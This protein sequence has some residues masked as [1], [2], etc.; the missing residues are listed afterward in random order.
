[1]SP[2]E[3]S[4]VPAGAPGDL[5]RKPGAIRAWLRLLASELRLIL[6][7]RRNQVGLAILAVVPVIVAVAIAANGG[8]GDLLGL[9]SANGVLVPLVA[10]MAES[11]FFL[12][13]AMAMVSG[14]AIA[15]EAGT[16]TLRYLLTVPVRR[17]RLLAVKYA[18]LV[19]G[20]FVA[21]A[22]IA[23]VGVIAGA[24]VVGTGPMVTFSGT[25]ITFAESLWR[26]AL[27]AAYLGV[28]MAAFASIG[29]FISTLTDQSVA[30]TI[31]L[32]ITTILSWIF[33]AIEQ[34]AWLHPFLPTHWLSSFTG[35]LYQPFDLAGVWSGLGY[36]G[37]VAVI[38]RLT[39][40]AHF[41][42]KDVTS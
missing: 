17:T 42:S 30:A 26:L 14:D 15:G 29:L 2:A 28:A 37:A 23:V 9:V 7:R 36:Y 3:R 10:L 27:A 18:A 13:L 35:F 12:P 39:A 31:A 33:E 41:T 4:A 19:I 16:G 20:G 40:W 22:A 34:V 21:V 8:R 32:M 25:E 24:A 11:S 5:G 6:G 1:M 38:F